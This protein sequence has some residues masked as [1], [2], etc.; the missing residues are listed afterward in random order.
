[1]T[2]LEGLEDDL[3]RLRRPGPEAVNVSNGFG[4]EHNV[5]LPY[6]LREEA[7]CSQAESMG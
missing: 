5:P 7:V 6:A 1:V 3:H 2:L 4:A